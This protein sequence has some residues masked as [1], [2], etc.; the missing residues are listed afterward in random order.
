[1]FEEPIEIGPDGAVRLPER[2]GLGV[3]LNQATVERYRV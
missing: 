1:L 2:P 3:T